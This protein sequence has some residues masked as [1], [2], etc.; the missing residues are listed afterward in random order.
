M[1]IG[2]KNTIDFNIN[3]LDLNLRK[4]TIDFNINSLDFNIRKK[5]IEFN[6]D[7]ITHYEYV[8]STGY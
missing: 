1:S 2:G 8:A 6:M 4:I 5:Y 3:I 7:I